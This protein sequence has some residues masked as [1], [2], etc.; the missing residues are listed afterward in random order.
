MTAMYF[1]GGY[2]AAYWA[3]GSLLPPGTIGLPPVHSALDRPSVY[4]HAPSWPYQRVAVLKSASNV[5][6][7]FTLMDV[8]RAQFNVSAVDPWVGPVTRVDGAFQPDA[9]QFN[10]FQLTASL[11]KD[12]RQD[13]ISRGNFIVIQSERYVRPWVGVITELDDQVSPGTVAVSALSIE[14]LMDTQP[15]PIA[16]SDYKGR[17]AGAILYE[18]LQLRNSQGHCGIYLPAVVPSGPA[19]D[20]SVSGQTVLATARDL[21]SRT[22][23][24][25]W[26]DPFDVSPRRIEMVM[27]FGYR[28]GTDKSAQIVL[29]EGRDFTELTRV[30]DTQ[31]LRQSVTVYG[32]GLSGDSSVTRSQSPASAHGQA[33]AVEPGSELYNRL[34]DVPPALRTSAILYRPLD[35]NRQALSQDAQRALERPNAAPERYKVTL[36]MASDW[37][38]IEEG[39]LIRII[40]STKEALGPFNRVLRVTALQPSEESGTIGLAVETPL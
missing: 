3:A 13:A 2:F 19:V 28:R 35:P 32:A 30:L 27:Q 38:Q 9:F 11:H 20:I 36:S 18:E 17:G 1:G 25:W 40:R 10:A 33:L 39:D 24:E 31:G 21:H 29:H 7:S 15:T 5:A 8:G 22:G 37:N 12:Y 6:R 34:V 16:T 26:V 23:W 4:V 14:S